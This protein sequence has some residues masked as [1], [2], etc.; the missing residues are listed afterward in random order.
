MPDDLA[1][2]VPYEDAFD[3]LNPPDVAQVKRVRAHALRALRQLLLELP[4]TQQE[5]AAQLGIKQP[6]LNRILRGEESAVSLDNLVLL[7]ARAG[8]RTSVVIEAGGRRR[9]IA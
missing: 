7:A 8:L 4:G 6:R 3:A 9:R 1:L 2:S 5:V